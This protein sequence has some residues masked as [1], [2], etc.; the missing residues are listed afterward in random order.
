MAIWTKPISTEILTTTHIAT[1]AERLGIEFIE[2]G[3]DFIRG[4]IPVDERTVQPYGVIHGG[5][6]VLLAETLGSCG[7]DYSTP[8][9]H[10]IVGLDINANH[11][12]GVAEGWVNGIARPVHI[13][14]ST[15][16]WSIRISDD[17]HGMDAAN[18]ARALAQFAAGKFTTRG[19]YANVFPGLHLVAEP[20]P[21]L[22]LRA[23]YNKS[24]TRPPVA[25]LLPTTNVNDDTRLITAGNPDLR[26]YTSDNFE[27]AVQRYFEPVGLFEVSAFLKR[28]S[29]YTRSV[30]GIV[31][32]GNDNGFEGQFA[33]YTL[34][35]TQNAGS[36][37]IRGVEVSYQQQ[38]TFLPGYWR[39]FGSF[40]NFTYTQ[41]EG[42]FGG[43]VVQNRIANQR[44][45][46]ANAGLSYVGFGAQLRLLA[47]W[48]D[49]YYRSGEGN[50]AVYSDPRLIV[51]FKGQYRINRRAELYLE[52]MNLTNEFAQTFVREGG[53]KYNAQKQ[54]T[55]YAMGVKLTY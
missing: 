30:D 37:R 54:G 3:P 46:A 33:G 24:I 13:G 17:G 15:Q 16:V 22:Q 45:R 9:G 12:R 2:I 55:L 25:N 43:L 28:I 39:G 34:R 51:D 29:N 42:D 50:A 52:V 21:R 11:N 48:N 4:R 6:S 10:R 35:Q 53:L 26:P 44:P 31:A 40:A 5:S 27:A 19:D 41:A 32:T 38:Y 49:R 8:I 14:R 23:S 20:R 47:N 36:A 7:A 18:A 1:A